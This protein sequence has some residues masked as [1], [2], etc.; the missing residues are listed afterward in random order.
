MS[1]RRAASAC[2][3]Q[4]RQGAPVSSIPWFGLDL[5]AAYSGDR[6]SPPARHLA[7]ELV[8][9]GQAETLEYDVAALGHGGWEQPTPPRHRVMGQCGFRNTASP[10]PSYPARTTPLSSGGRAERL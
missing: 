6:Q 3:L 8:G 5:A 10:A 7:P 9:P 2:S 4:A 1:C